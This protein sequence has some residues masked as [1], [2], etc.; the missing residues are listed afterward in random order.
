MH[1]CKLING[2]G[3]GYITTHDAHLAREL[4][5]MRGFGFEDRDH[6]TVPGGLN[7]K[8]N[9][10][11]AAAALASLDTVEEQIL[12]NEERY[13]AYREGLRAIPDIRLLEFDENT[14]PGYKNIVVELLKGWPLSQADT[15]AVLNAENIL[16]RAYYPEPLHRKPMR[17]PSVHA[18]LPLTDRLSKR[19][20]NLPCGQLVSVDD[21]HQIVEILSFIRN[22]SH[23]ITA[24][25]HALVS[26]AS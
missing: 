1:V 19:F 14:R 12:R 6:V 3:G 23:S 26:A 20:L 15:V 25:L 24:R 16:A 8:L 2:F 11:H 13:V 18:E 4:A 7:A 22:N 5:L 21:I 9:E 17:Y 10:I